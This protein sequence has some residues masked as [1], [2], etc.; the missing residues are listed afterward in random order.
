MVNF[1]WIK[2]RIQYVFCRLSAELSD[3]VG[4]D[5]DGLPQWF[6]TQFLFGN[7]LNLWTGMR[8][9]QE[10]GQHLT[11]RFSAIISDSASG[12]GGRAPKVLKCSTAVA[13]IYE[14]SRTKVLKVGI[15]RQRR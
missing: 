11:G 3:S 2:K 5:S 7:Y 14:H 8:L 9:R 15:L 6:A 12:S 1:Y 4:A 10:P 13:L